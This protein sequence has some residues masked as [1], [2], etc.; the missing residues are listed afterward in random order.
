MSYHLTSARVSDLFQPVSSGRISTDIVE[1]VKDAIRRG[2]LR[3]GDRLPPE[4]DLTEQLGVSRVSVR[5][6]LRVLEAHGLVEVRVGARGGAYV[7]V[8]AP[9]LVGE[10]ISNMLMLASVS[11][12]EVT[13]MRHVFELAILPLVCERATEDDVAALEDV[14]ER[15]EASFAGGDYDVALSTEFHTLLA[16]AT[17]NSAVS[18]IAESLRGPL[19]M[20]LRLAQRAAPE[21]GG[22]GVREHRAIVDAIRERNA[23]KAQQIMA[24]HLARTAERVAA[25]GAPVDGDGRPSA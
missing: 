24:A 10:G 2:E 19:L 6:A 17:H 23:E 9:T 8:P 18:M 14:C 12:R 21:M 20:S 13:E 1:Q 4:R 5:D 11:A 7:T 25:D 16:R 15:S 3:P 22:A